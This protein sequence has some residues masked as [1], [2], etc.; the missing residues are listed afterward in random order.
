[1]MACTMCSIHWCLSMRLTDLQTAKVDIQEMQELELPNAGDLECENI[2]MTPIPRCLPQ[3]APGKQ[4]CPG[5]PDVKRIY[6][7]VAPETSKR[8]NFRC[9]KSQVC[10]VTVDAKTLAGDTNAHYDQNH[11]LVED[12]TQFA[13]AVAKYNN[14][15]DLYRQAFP[16]MSRCVGLTRSECLDNEQS[17]FMASTAYCDDFQGLAK[18]K[19]LLTAM[20]NRMQTSN[21]FYTH[22]SYEVPSH[23]RGGI[24]ELL[25]HDNARPVDLSPAAEEYW[26]DPSELMRDGQGDCEDFAFLNQ[27][28]CGKLVASGLLDGQCYVVLGFVNHDPDGGHAISVYQDHA[29]GEAYVIDGTFHCQRDETTLTDDTT[30]DTNSLMP[31]EDYLSADCSEVYCRNFQVTGSAVV[32]N[33]SCFQGGDE[34]CQYERSWGPPVAALKHVNGGQT[35]DDSVSNVDLKTARYEH[36]GLAP[37]LDKWDFE[38]AQTFMQ[39]QFVAASLKFNNPANV[40]FLNQDDIQEWS[41][42]F[43]QVLDQAAGS[44]VSAIFA[45]HQLRQSNKKRNALKKLGELLDL[46]EKEWKGKTFRGKKLKRLLYLMADVFCSNDEDGAVQC[47]QEAD[48]SVKPTGHAKVAN[49]LV[50]FHRRDATFSFLNEVCEHVLVRLEYLHTL[51][52]GDMPEARLD[53]DR[54]VNVT[55]KKEHDQLNKELLEVAGVVGIDWKVKRQNV[56]FWSRKLKSGLLPPLQYKLKT[57]NA[58][59][60]SYLTPKFSTEDLRSFLVNHSHTVRVLSSLSLYNQYEQD[61]WFRQSLW[62][63]AGSTAMSFVPLFGAQDFMRS[64]FYFKSAAFHTLR[65]RALQNRVLVA[66]HLLRWSP[67][68]VGTETDRQLGK[69]FMKNLSAYSFRERENILVLMRQDK[70][71]GIIH[72]GSGISAGPSYALGPIGSFGRVLVRSLLKLIVWGF[73]NLLKRQNTKNIPIIDVAEMFELLEPFPK[74]CSSNLAKTLFDLNHH[75]YEAIATG[76]W[77]RKGIFVPSMA[78]PS[79][80]RVKLWKTR[81]GSG[82][83]RFLR[84]WKAL[85]I[86]PPEVGFGLHSLVECEPQPKCLSSAQATTQAVFFLRVTAWKT[87]NSTLSRGRKPEKSAMKQWNKKKVDQKVHLNDIIMTVNGR[88][89]QHHTNNLLDDIDKPDDN[90]RVTLQVL[91]GFVT[92]PSLVECDGRSLRSKE[93]VFEANDPNAPKLTYHKDSKLVK[94]KKWSRWWHRFRN[95]RVAAHV[96]VQPERVYACEHLCLGDPACDSVEVLLTLEPTKVHCELFQDDE[97]ISHRKRDQLVP[98][99]GATKSERTCWTRMRLAKE[100]AKVLERPGGTLKAETGQP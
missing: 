85:R 56:S 29:T 86:A 42:D 21:L 10:C 66:E 61:H 34:L 4:V 67:P 27:M 46:D 26:K 88:S 51:S 54:F 17:V 49:A 63:A 31:Y 1:M 39:A 45:Y 76:N 69:F 11:N 3:L 7:P 100:E 38:N 73:F 84:Q 13:A 53:C 44:W 62:K 99:G 81:L 48:K 91:P 6:D 14:D 93:F 87:R 23:Y 57:R 22:D 68:C 72:I 82:A 89:P 59:L 35:I 96:A 5:A 60:I 12:G 90:M 30:F 9:P 32:K 41:Q 8:R 64:Y 94:K 2:P 15:Q 24:F 78:V 95:N 98:T 83:P 28:Y 20:Q 97:S 33:P 58:D 80:L 25:D 74:L 50:L 40:D 37:H 79:F 77:I 36:A 92:F 55:A 75:Q 52:F 18:T 16:E 43:T 71:Y 47:F 65:K 70:A 19:C